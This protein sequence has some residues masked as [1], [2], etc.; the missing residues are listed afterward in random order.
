MFPLVR[1]NSG[2]GNL[3]VIQHPSDGDLS[4]RLV[5]RAANVDQ[6][7]DEGDFN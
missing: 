3:G 6:E 5:V 7:L 4:G 1:P 2:R